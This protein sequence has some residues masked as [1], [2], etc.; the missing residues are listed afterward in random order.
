MP[1][2]VSTL[3]N[4]IYSAPARLVQTFLQGML[5]V[6]QPRHL[7]RFKTMAICALIFIPFHLSSLSDHDHLISLGT[8]WAI[9]VETI[10]QLGIPTDHLSRLHQ[11]A[12]NTIV[13]PASLPRKL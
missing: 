2:L 10:A 3:L 11:D 7:S 13:G 1:G 6:W 8:S 9:I 12:G 5:Q 4:Q